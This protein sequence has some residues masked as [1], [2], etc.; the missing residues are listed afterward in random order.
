MFYP[1][2]PLKLWETWILFAPF[3]GTFQIGCTTPFL[4][5]DGHP[6]INGINGYV[7]VQEEIIWFTI[8]GVKTLWKVTT[9]AETLEHTYCLL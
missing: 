7:G 5:K 1:Q 4:I 8:L 6:K 2:I 3:A 9:T